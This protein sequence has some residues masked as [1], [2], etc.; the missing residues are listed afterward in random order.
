[1]ESKARNHFNVYQSNH[2]RDTKGWGLIRSLYND[3]KV[4]RKMESFL[5]ENTKFYY[6]INRMN[7]QR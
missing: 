1:M 4:Q 2:S 6:Y 3:I 7:I 5:A